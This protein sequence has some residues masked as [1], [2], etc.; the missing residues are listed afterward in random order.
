MLGIVEHLC[1]SLENLEMKRNK[2]PLV[3]WLLNLFLNSYEIELKIIDEPGAEYPFGGKSLLDQQQFSMT[4]PGSIHS[5]F[6]K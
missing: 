5:Q 1:C 4:N 2:I 3:L 6:I